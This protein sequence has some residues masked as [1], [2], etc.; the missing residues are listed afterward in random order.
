MNKCKHCKE[1]FDLCDKPSGWMANH[2]RWCKENPKRTEY[3]NGSLK[4]VA[5]MNLAKKE[6]GITNQYDKAKSEGKQIVSP[7]TNNNYWKG[8]KH[9]EK[10]KQLMKEKAL[11]S[12]HR[13]LR[14]GIIEYNGIML[15]SSWELELAK[16]LDE[17]NITWIRPNPLPWID[18][19]GI[20]HNYFPDFYLPEY[21]LYLDPKNP[22]VIKVQNEKLKCLLSQY[23]NIVI[24]NSLESCKN[25]NISN[26]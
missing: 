1:E 12:P 26:K 14:R 7:L 16:R 2:S 8:R 20:I 19:D 25:Y 23:D 10:S 13:R 3:K 22:Q 24:L 17:C 6:S 21:N 5:A 15:D 9:T 11:S 4:A 18:K